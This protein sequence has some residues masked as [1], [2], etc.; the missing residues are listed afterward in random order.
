[1][2]VATSEEGRAWNV[3]WSGDV[4]AHAILGAMTDPKRLRIVLSFPSRPAR[5][6]VLRASPAGNDV[7]WTIA[8]LEVW[9]ASAEVR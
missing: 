1:M 6:I 3:A 8:E 5:Y 9:S 7:P 4:L 2:Q